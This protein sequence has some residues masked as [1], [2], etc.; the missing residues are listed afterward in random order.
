MKIGGEVVAV[1]LKIGP[2]GDGTRYWWS[3]VFSRAG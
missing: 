1:W 3:I 2:V